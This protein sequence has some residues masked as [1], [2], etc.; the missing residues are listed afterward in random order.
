M[1]RARLATPALLLL[2]AFVLGPER[3]T[4][5]PTE[6]PAP[7]AAARTALARIACELARALPASAASAEVVVVRLDSDVELP[8]PLLLRE[9]VKELV[10]GALVRPDAPNPS[11]HNAR[12]RLRLEL[13][14]EIK[15]PKLRVTAD[16]RRGSGLWQRVRRAARAVELHAFAESPLDAELRSLIPPPPLVITELIKLKS[17]ERGIIALACGAWGEDGGQELVLL[18]RSQLRVGRIASRAFVERRRLSVSSLSAVAAAPLRE[19]LATAE[20]TPAGRLRLGL[21]DRQDGLELDASLTVTRRFP[22]LLP[23]PG[24]GCVAR[25][26]LG[27]GGKLGPCSAGDV[28]SSVDLS[29]ILDALA[30][31]TQLQLGRSLDAGKLLGLPA[32]AGLSARVGAQLAVGDADGDGSPEL[33]FAADTLDPARDRV[34]LVTLS[35]SK[36]IPRFEL[37][38]PNGVTALAICN[39]RDG[40]GMAP[41][42]VA[43]GE[44]LWLVR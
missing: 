15:G 13:S 3:A 5:A 21:S 9:R 16:G 2:A 36:L 4:G 19:P 43:T 18:S 1:S 29:G 23:A 39:E 8:K 32:N 28:A 44:E 42:V 11:A 25:S 27:V 31:S 40:R 14:L 26:G 34:S 41:L 33:A 24:G 30:G 7:C 35:G 37:S 10:S 20:L 22:G 17:P 6:T 12:T 38:A